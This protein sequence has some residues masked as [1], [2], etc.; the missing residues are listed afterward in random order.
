[1]HFQQLQQR[2]ASCSQASCSYAARP[3]AQ[4]SQQRRST[5][6]SRHA[7]ITRRH[8][9]GHTCRAID[10]DDSTAAEQIALDT[11]QD[12]VYDKMTFASNTT[13]D[14]DDPQWVEKVGDWQDF[15]YNTEDED[16]GF[17]DDELSQAERSELSLERAR[18]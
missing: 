7:S 11:R 9:S 16:L 1:M 2:L 4:C 3:A 12:T 5:Y 17:D 8:R 14:Y 6:A 10:D 18:E 15:W 13:P